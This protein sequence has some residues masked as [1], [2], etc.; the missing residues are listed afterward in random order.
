MQMMNQWHACL[1]IHTEEGIKKNVWKKNAFQDEEQWLQFASVPIP[2]RTPSLCTDDCACGAVGAFSA[3]WH[4]YMQMGKENKNTRRRPPA[5]NTR[6]TLRF[7]FFFEIEERYVG[8]Q[9]DKQTRTV[10]GC[11]GSCQKN[12]WRRTSATHT[13]IL[14]FFTEKKNHNIQYI[15]SWIMLGESCLV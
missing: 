7:F 11:T 1:I 5:R 15:F 4:V 8:R 12:H 13:Q 10:V 14:F 2:S 9:Q 3:I 6:G